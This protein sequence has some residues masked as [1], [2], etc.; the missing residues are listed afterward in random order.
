M[1]DVKQQTIAD[2]SKNSDRKKTECSQNDLIRLENFPNLARKV[3]AGE[4]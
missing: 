1:N 3:E 4:V 2:D